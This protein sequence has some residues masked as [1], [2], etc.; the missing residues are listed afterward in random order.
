MNRNDILDA[1]ASVLNYISNFIPKDDNY[2]L[3]YEFVVGVP[4]SVAE[5][6]VVMLSVNAALAA[7]PQGRRLWCSINRKNVRG[8]GITIMS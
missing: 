3:S 2:T 5:Q 8:F 4:L 1:V 6:E 7:F